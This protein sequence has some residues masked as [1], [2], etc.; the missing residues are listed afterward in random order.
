MPQGQSGHARGAREREWSCFLMQPSPQDNWLPAPDGIVSFRPTPKGDVG[1]M[2]GPPP[3]AIAAPT[4]KQARSVV[5]GD[6]HSK[7]VTASTGQA[8]RPTFSSL[9][10]CR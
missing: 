10:G 7:V 9:R 5:N 6:N 1:S 3:V 2:V 4:P 8:K